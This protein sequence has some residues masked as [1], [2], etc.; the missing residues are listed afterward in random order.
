LVDERSIDSIAPR[1]RAATSTGTASSFS[2]STS[3]FSPDSVAVEASPVLASLSP[4]HEAPRP[5]STAIT[6]ANRS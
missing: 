1:P 5:S 3:P 4:V 6:R 2:S